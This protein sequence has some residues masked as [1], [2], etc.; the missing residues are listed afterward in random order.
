MVIWTKY[1]SPHS[2]TD[3]VCPFTLIVS[4][5]HQINCVTVL[6]TGTVNMP[7]VWVLTVKAICFD[8]RHSHNSNLLPHGYQ[9]GTCTYQPGC[10]NRFGYNCWFQS[11]DLMF[12]SFH[13]LSHLDI[14]RLF[15]K[16]WLS[17]IIVFFWCIVHHN[18]QT[19][20][21]HGQCAILK[22]RYNGAPTIFQLAASLIW[23]AIGCRH[24]QMRYWPTL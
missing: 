1:K 9:T 14:I 15:G 3:C 4:V 16:Y 24:S 7:A 12:V 5:I 10:C 23:V 21:R 18:T 2:L 8:P 13:W 22:M 20:E 17:Y 19:V 6:A 11:L